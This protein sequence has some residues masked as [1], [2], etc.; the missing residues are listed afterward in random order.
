MASSDPKRQQALKEEL[1][2]LFK[3]RSKI[4]ENRRDLSEL[5]KTLPTLC[6][7]AQPLSS[8][9]EWE[10]DAHKCIFAVLHKSINAA[11]DVRIPL[12]TRMPKKKTKVTQRELALGMYKYP[13]PGENSYKGHLYSYLLDLVYLPHGENREE[14]SDDVK[15]EWSNTL[16]SALAAD[17]LKRESDELAKVVDPLAPVEIVQEHPPFFERVNEQ[18]QLKRWIRG[19]GKI[20]L[21][22]GD[23]GNG[24]SSIAIETLKL[25][26]ETEFFKIVTVDAST[27]YSFKNSMNDHVHQPASVDLPGVINK[28]TDFLTGLPLLSIL[29]I[30]NAPD[31]DTIKDLVWA[32]HRAIVTAEEPIIPSNYAHAVIPVGPPTVEVATHI[33][34]SAAF[35]PHATDEAADRFAMAVNC[36]PRII[37][38]CLGM[39]SE[40]NMTLDQMSEFVNF[41]ADETLETAGTNERSVHKLYGIYFER[42]SKAKRTTALC[43]E[44]LAHLDQPVLPKSVLS[45]TLVQLFQTSEPGTLSPANVASPL[46]TLESRFL[47]EL[48]QDEVH[49]HAVTMRLF[50]KVTAERRVAVFNAVIDGYAQHREDIASSSILV[51]GVIEWIPSLGRVLLNSTTSELMRWKQENADL[52]VSSLRRGLRQLGKFAELLIVVRFLGGQ[53]QFADERLDYVETKKWAEA[54]YESGYLSRIRYQFMLE[55]DLENANFRDELDHVQTTYAWAR[56]SYD[57]RN[58]LQWAESQWRKISSGSPQASDDCFYHIARSRAITLEWLGN[59]WDAEKDYRQLINAMPTSADVDALDV[60]RRGIA[61]AS[62]LGN[63]DRTKEWMDFAHKLY[64]RIRGT[65]EEHVAGAN[66][67]IAQGWRHRLTIGDENNDGRLPRDNFFLGATALYSVGS[68]R[69]ALEVFTE[70]VA[71]D[72]WVRLKS[73]QAEEDPLAQKVGYELL[74]G[75]SRKIDEP[76]SEN[77]LHLIRAI[78]A[79]LKAAP[80]E[81]VITA[82]DKAARRADEEFCDGRTKKQALLAA[83]LFRDRLKLDYSPLS[84]AL[85]LA[86]KR[87]HGGEMEREEFESWLRNTIHDLPEYVLLL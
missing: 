46:K 39:F 75:L 74:D 73:V 49:M 63:L 55:G 37:I 48:K 32:S 86:Q 35:R 11:L 71:L 33:I 17:L 6:K 64:E 87:W 54:G 47:V 45:E 22:A 26:K 4:D 34:K 82:I 81:L 50:R 10:R 68:R 83:I 14:Y 58:Y 13:A 72:E 30:D 19:R 85:Y 69:A 25:E 76:H 15:A 27:P 70:V 28:F 31:W 41:D 61:C 43:L 65:A 7:I 8:E 84:E 44:T 1:D 18:D 3:S 29:L 67:L 51:P 42:I 59:T 20:M 52:V 12:D 66:Y 53:P 56:T 80:A 21:L 57:L 79:G 9:D 2:K 16:R 23:S 60:A 38:D 78:A 77:R 36:N 24:K 5:K 62:K 40:E